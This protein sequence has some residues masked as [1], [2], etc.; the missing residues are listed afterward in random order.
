ML[1]SLRNIVGLDYEVE[2]LLKKQNISTI[3]VF[4]KNTRKKEDRIALA[5]KTDIFIEDINYWALQAEFL[6]IEGLFPEDT[7]YLIQAGFTNCS[8]V[9]RSNSEKLKEVLKYF[10][11]EEIDTIK[12]SHLHKEN[13][14]D[15]SNFNLEH[16][17][18]LATTHLKYKNFSIGRRHSLSNYDK[19]KSLL[20]FSNVISELGKGIVEA[21]IN[22]N[23]R[24]IEMQNKILE[25]DN[26]NN[27]GINA[28]WYTIPEVEFELAM[29]YKLINNINF[30]KYIDLNESEKLSVK[31]RMILK[32]MSNID[33][34]LNKSNG[35]LKLKIIPFHED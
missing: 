13:T 30:T 5:K 3:K 4:C 24:S 33:S 14:L 11:I 32:P 8:D 29:E 15:I 27:L 6:R 7:L 34:L 19:Y 25:D 2:R 20:D 26:L 12:K 21:Q 18:N 31:P 23:K 9:R 17:K 1:Y 10:S 28:T 22:L 16:I 35:T